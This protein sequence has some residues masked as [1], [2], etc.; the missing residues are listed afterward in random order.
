MRKPLVLLCLLTLVAGCLPEEQLATV[1]L[2]GG[3]EVTMRI[4]GL[5]GLHRDWRRALQVNSPQG[6]AELNLP[7]DTGWWRGSN[8][9][10]WKAD[11][12]VLHEGQAGCVQFRIDPA[13]LLA[14]QRDV[15]DK[16]KVGAN[17]ISSK[18]QD[19]MSSGPPS[20]HYPGLI[21][22]GR[23]V[24][25]SNKRSPL[26]FIGADEAPETELPDIL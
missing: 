15:C 13:A 8:L 5:Y 4:R 19:T 12:Y 10:L 11:V 25:G 9:Y 14:E 21:Y 16:M 18:R 26:R 2:A 24:E 20:R 23:F 6:R 1:P 3:S 7:D 17:E 22:L